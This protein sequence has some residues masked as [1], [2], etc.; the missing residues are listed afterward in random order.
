MKKALV[1]SFDLGIRGDYEGMYK[2]LAR[3]GAKECGDSSAFLSYEYSGPDNDPL[4]HIKQ[5]I[6]QNVEVDK[7]TRVYLMRFVDGKAKGTFVFG[8]RHVAPWANYAETDEV[9]EDT[10]A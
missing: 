6:A 7:N 9:A 2:W 10:D 3:N 5:E 4:P 1:I 8:K